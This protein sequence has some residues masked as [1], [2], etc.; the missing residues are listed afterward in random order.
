MEESR[1]KFL[2]EHCHVWIAILANSARISGDEDRLNVQDWGNGDK[3]SGSQGATLPSTFSR[4][5]NSV[6]MCGF[7]SILSTILPLKNILS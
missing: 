3:E 5:V 7:H 2:L 4:C 1:P 6:N